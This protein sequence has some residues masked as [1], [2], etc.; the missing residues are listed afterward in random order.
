MRVTHGEEDPSTANQ[1]PGS[2]LQ[3]SRWER[4]LGELW[5]ETEAR[6][7]E[8]LLPSLPSPSNPA[9]SQPMGITTLTVSY[10]RFASISPSVMPEVQ[11]TPLPDQVYCRSSKR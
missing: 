6:Q 3:G 7:G 8:A 5:A 1:G 9:L 4:G 10:L 2:G 11:L